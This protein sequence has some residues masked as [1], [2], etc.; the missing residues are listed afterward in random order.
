MLLIFHHEGG[1]TIDGSGRQGGDQGEGGKLTAAR[2]P[3]EK[4]HDEILGFFDLPT[5]KEQPLSSNHTT[6]RER[7]SDAA[8]QPY[9]VVLPSSRILLCSQ[10]AVHSCVAKQP[11]FRAHHLV[12]IQRESLI[13]RR[14]EC[15][16][17]YFCLVSLGSFGVGRQC[18]IAPEGTWP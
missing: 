1:M 6:L 7:T 9:I 13:P 11:T 12:N 2:V 15:V 17:F 5:D 14:R 3:I 16:F 10:A 4:R 8:K 18:E